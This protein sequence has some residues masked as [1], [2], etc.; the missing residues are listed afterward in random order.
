MVLKALLSF[1]GLGIA[2]LLLSGGAARSVT[3][4]VSRHAPSAG[5]FP[6]DSVRA[7]LA[8]YRW[9][10][11][12]FLTITSSF[13]DFRTTHFHGGI[14][15]SSH[16]KTGYRVFAS[17]SGYISHIS[18]SPYGYGKLLLVQHADGYVTAYAHLSRFNDTLEA[19]VEMLQHQ[20]DRY[21]LEVN[22]QPDWFPVSLGD[23]IAYTGNTGTGTAHLHFEIHDENFDPVNPLLVPE[24]SQYIKDS[25]TPEIRKIAFVP[26][27]ASSRVNNGNKV[28]ILSASKVGTRTYQFRN[29]VRCT[30][31]I[32]IELY[33]MDHSDDTWYRSTA[34]DV[35]MYV[36]SIS[37]F[38]SRIVRVSL[39]ETKQIAL[40]FDWGMRQKRGGYFQKLYVEPGD[41]QP[42]Y[43]GEP[44]CWSGL[45]TDRFDGGYHTLRMVVSDV[46][47]NN[48]ELKGTVIFNHP[49]RINA[50]RDAK[51]A[52]LYISS[53]SPLRSVHVST[54][55]SG[56]WN[57]RSYPASRLVGDKYGYTLSIP[58]N[59]NTI[60]KAQAENIYSTTSNPEFLIPAV[61]VP[62]KI[63]FRFRKEFFRDYLSV[64]LSSSAMLSTPPL[65]FVDSENG[66]RQIPLDQRDLTKYVGIYQLSAADHGSIR[67]VA[68][69]DSSDPNWQTLDEFVLFPVT[70][71]N[72]GVVSGENGEFRLIFGPGGVYRPTFFRVECT[73]EGYSVIP[74]DV[75]L[76]KGSIVEYTLSTVRA[77]KVGLFYGNEILDWTNPGEKNILRG[78][79]DR[80]VGRFSL[81]EDHDPPEISRVQTSY[82][83]GKVR[84]FFRLFD[85]CAGIDPDS[86][87]I[88]VDNEVLIGEFNPHSH[89]VRSEEFHP[90]SRGTHIITIES[91]DRMANKTVV[92]RPLVVTR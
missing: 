38:S 73:Y 13:A 92:H 60:L 85:E 12:D 14:D 22:L 57:T 48:S 71:E 15:I 65:L 7:K 81:I 25:V 54:L 39:A 56:K 42:F 77:H 75:L 66:S 74:N 23:V 10:T 37:V 89:S 31:T 45:Q 68:R 11:E 70:P 84:I 55:V 30:G 51:T 88:R 20:N 83:R 62:Q 50:N 64:T 36:D 46:F 44:R 21:P 3:S 79:I 72:G 80:F 26:L 47:G 58:T 53:A 5:Y 2:T 59:Q 91:S 17:R 32:G 63:S 9:P 18:I 86:I 35:E 76:N 69:V 49:P 19:Y 87:R 78:P 16:R 40:H 1:F 82:S 33:A 34:T 24:F 28:V 29:V 52:V 8:G 43:S 61:Q 90:L 41:Q 4:P 27:D 6:Y 67:V